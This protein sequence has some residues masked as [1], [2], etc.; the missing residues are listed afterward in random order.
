MLANEYIFPLSR[1]RERAGFSRRFGIQPAGRK[2]PKALG[3]PGE[4]NDAAHPL[5]RILQS[6]RSYKIHPLPQAGEGKEEDMAWH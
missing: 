1:L 5:T 2:M 3:K 4:G 6:L